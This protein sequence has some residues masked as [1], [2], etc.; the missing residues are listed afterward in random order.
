M[1]VDYRAISTAIKTHLQTELGSGYFVTTNISEALSNTQI[2]MCVLVTFQSMRLLENL[3]LIPNEPCRDATYIVGI[4]ARRDNDEAQ[5]I[6]ID[7][8]IPL[9]EEACNSIGHG[10]PPFG[11]SEIEL[12][13]CNNAEK[14]IDSNAGITAT[15]TLNVR[16]ME[17]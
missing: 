13:T 9:I 1:S 5:D 11:R 7:T 8:A 16:I 14:M 17:E 2:P 6:A 15:I 12:A 4:I 3:S 10:F